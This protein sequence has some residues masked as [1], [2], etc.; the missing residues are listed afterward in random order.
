MHPYKVCVFNRFYSKNLQVLFLSLAPPTGTRCSFLCAVL[1]RDTTPLIPLHL[2]IGCP[3]PPPRACHSPRPAC[4]LGTTLSLSAFCVSN[5]TLDAPLRGEGEGHVAAHFACARHTP[6]SVCH[7]MTTLL[8][9]AFC[10]LSSLTTFRVLSS[11]TTFRVLSLL[12]AFCMSSLDAHWPHSVHCHCHTPV[13]HL[14]AC[15][16]LGS[17]K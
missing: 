12:A 9:A 15:T 3:P 11:L 1:G 4:H 7:L 16:I 17:I 10:M 8:L 2:I 5:D 13:R 6:Y 14:C